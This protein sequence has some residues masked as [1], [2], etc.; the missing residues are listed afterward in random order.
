MTARTFKLR[1]KKYLGQQKWDSL[2]VE[3]KD[4][5]VNGVTEGGYGH[6]T[7]RNTGVCIYVDCRTLNNV[8]AGIRDKVMVRYAKDNKDWSSN[9]IGV[10]GRNRWFKESELY[11]NIE[12]MLGAPIE[13]VMSGRV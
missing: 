10:A 11:K 1:L 5:K 12:Y 4:S 2:I 7:N 13:A 8:Y 3:V 9:G 6:I